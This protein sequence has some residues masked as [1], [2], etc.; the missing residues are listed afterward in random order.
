MHLII[1]YLS[2]ASTRL[3]NWSNANTFECYFQMTAITTTICW[4]Q[5]WWQWKTKEKLHILHTVLSQGYY[6]GNLSVFVLP[7][8]NRLLIVVD[9]DISIQFI[10][11]YLVHC[12]VIA[13]LFSFCSFVYL[14]WRAVLCDSLLLQILT[15]VGEMRLKVLWEPGSFA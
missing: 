6:F 4:F 3:H 14:V 5:P 1:H 12:F 15:H 2:L 8:N 10:S 13:L 9:D 11:V 7:N